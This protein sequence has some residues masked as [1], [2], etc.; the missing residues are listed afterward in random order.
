MARSDSELEIAAG[1]VQYE[2]DALVGCYR[3]FLAAE[4]E[5]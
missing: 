2:L 4:E 5:F 3:R 1:H